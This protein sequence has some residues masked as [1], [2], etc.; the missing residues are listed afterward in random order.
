[1]LEYSLDGVQ[2]QSMANRLD[3]RTGFFKWQ[4]PDTVSTAL[5]RVTQGGRLILSDSFAISRQENLNVGFNCPDSV[6]LYW[7]SLPVGQYQLYML[8]SRY[9]EPV[10]RTNDT[11]KIFKKNNL[12]SEYVAVAPVID[13]KTGKRSFTLNFA[14]QGVGCYLRSF[15]VIL[16]NGKEALLSSELGSLYGVKEMAYQKLTSSGYQTIHTMPGVGLLTQTFVDSNLVPGAN[17]YRLQII[18]L[19]GGVIYSA[20]DKVY[21]L[22][23]NPVL[24][25]P[26]PARRNETIQIVT[27]DPGKYTLHVLDVNGR[28]VRTLFIQDI[29]QPLPSLQLGTGMYF[30]KIISDEGKT[31]QQKL[32]VL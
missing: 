22:P 32:I 17:F 31:Y 15:Y 6:L 4:V 27:G 5:L 30:I 2:W 18:L 8:G 23:H 14:R 29:L 21:Y 26:N 1:M 16:Q 9:M 28:M 11:V 12:P 10:E 20:P 3:A 13:K 25:F 19:N 7:N 24:V